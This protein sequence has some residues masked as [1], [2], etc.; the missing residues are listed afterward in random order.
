MRTV[1]SSIPLLLV[2]AL[3]ATAYS[4]YFDWG[5]SSWVWFQRSGS[6]LA[7]AGA[8]LG[9]RSIVRLGVHGVGGASPTFLKATLV[10][11]DDSG[12]RQMAKVSYDE[13]TLSTLR[14][15]AVDRN[16]GYVGAYMM[17]SGTVIW[18]YGDL[19]GALF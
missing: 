2:A 18:G 15:A 5:T 11:I 16:A 8:V 1:L 17:V 4:V 19:A 13:E 10:S 9:Y 14:Q 6:L 12:Q 7:L 3:A